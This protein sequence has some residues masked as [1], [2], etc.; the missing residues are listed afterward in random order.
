MDR[1]RHPRRRPPADRQ[2]R[3][4]NLQQGHLRLQPLGRRRHRRAG[5]ARL[6]RRRRRQGHLRRRQR[7]VPVGHPSGRCRRHRR[8]DP[9]LRRSPARQALPVRGNRV[10][11]LRLLGPG[12]DGLPR[13]RDRHPPHEPGP[14]GLRTRSPPARSSPATR[15]LFRSRR[16]P[17]APGHV[18]I[19]LNPAAHTIEEDTYGLPTS[20]AGLSPVVGFT[21][22]ESMLGRPQCGGR[23]GMAAG[24]GQRPLP[25]GS[26][27]G[28]P[29]RAAGGTR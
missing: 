23:P 10:G 16:H 5:P 29:S 2:R 11:R 26:R 13:R 3:A 15:L 8:E 25:A 17:A 12:N 21:R 20:K 27:R 1:R 18:G 24:G 28:A 22:R 4:G 6:L 9:R 14:V 7:H 19:V